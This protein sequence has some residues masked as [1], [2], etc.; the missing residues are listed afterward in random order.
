MS[1]RDY[2][3]SYQ[4][5]RLVNSSARRSSAGRSVRVLIIVLDIGI[6]L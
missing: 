4:T 6:R 1:H 3:I 2:F 5:P